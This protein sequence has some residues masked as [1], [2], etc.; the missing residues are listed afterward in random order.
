MENLQLDGIAIRTDK[1]RHL[2]PGERFL[3]LAEA[4][5]QCHPQHGLPG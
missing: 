1:S 4:H 3:V 2:S 5:F